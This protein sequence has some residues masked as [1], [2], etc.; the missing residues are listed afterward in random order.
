MGLSYKKHIRKVITD[1][2]PD[3]ELDEEAANE[4][5]LLVQYLAKRII[6]EAD[7]ITSM[8]GLQTIKTGAIQTA[9][10]TT[11]RGELRRLSS[12]EGT[13][14]VIRYTGKDK[15]RSPIFPVRLTSTLIKQYVKAQRVSMTAAV[16]LAVVLEYLTAEILSLAG[17]IT[18]KDKRTVMNTRDIK[19]AINDDEELLGLFHRVTL[20]GG[21]QPYIHTVLYPRGYEI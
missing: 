3:L 21:V 8:S 11:L 5:D 6:A 16:Y 2:H 14:A 13:D 4:C 15:S 19:L 12:K 10:T 18:S 20:S 17:L 9:V 1:V 7:K